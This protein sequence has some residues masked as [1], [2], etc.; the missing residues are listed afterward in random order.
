MKNTRG[1]PSG[2]GQTAPESE[3]RTQRAFGI[4]IYRKTASGMAPA[5]L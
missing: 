3:Q 5:H 2:R 1:V 4:I